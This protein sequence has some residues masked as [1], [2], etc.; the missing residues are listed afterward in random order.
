M[1]YAAA[2]QAAA[3]TTYPFDFTAQPV[4]QSVLAQPQVQQ[5]EVQQQQTYQMPVQQFQQQ[6]L[7]P[8]A[9]MIAYPQANQFNFAPQA[10]PAEVAPVAVQPA[11]A[12]AV[13]A[14]AP[15]VAAAPAKRDTKKPSKG[16]KKNK[17]CC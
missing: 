16:K 12:Q 14:A 17:G 2:P 3:T 8:A 10:A 5:Y 9:S 13:V 1:T 15:E 6:Q 7:Q 11:A 4:Q